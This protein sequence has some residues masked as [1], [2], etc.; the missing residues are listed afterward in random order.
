MDATR[1]RDNH[2]VMLKV[3]YPAE[4]PHELMINKFFSSPELAKMPD[5]HCA[6]LLDVIELR[7]PEPQKLMVFPFL[8]PFNQPKIQ[9]IGEFVAFF[10]QICDVR[11]IR[12]N[13]I[14]VFNDWFHR[15][16]DLCTSEMS[17]I[18]K[19]SL[20][21]EYVLGLNDSVAIARQTISCLTRQKC[22]RM[23]SIRSKSTVIGT[24][25]VLRRLTRGPSVLRFTISLTL[26]CHVSTPHGM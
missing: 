2:Q 4:G 8:R 7:R 13:F 25:R 6:P 26:V 10:T 17:P 1:M 9:T 16:F 12:P 24:S 5:N 18:G 3:I 20:S 19:K 14:P 22:I 11:H 23:G 21:I 15:A